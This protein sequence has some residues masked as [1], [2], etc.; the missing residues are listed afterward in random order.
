M[1]M[2]Q[3]YVSYNAATKMH[4]KFYVRYCVFPHNNQRARFNL[5]SLTHY[6][7]EK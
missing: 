1:N 7:Y 2:F 5:M 3:N 6:N 4:T